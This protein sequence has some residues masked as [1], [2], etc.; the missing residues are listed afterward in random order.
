MIIIITGATHTGKTNLAQSLLNKNQFPYLSLDHLK[1]G[2]IRSHNSSLSTNDDD[3]LTEYLW[4]ITKE[5][6]KT[7][8]EN[9]QNLIIEGKYIPPTWQ[10]DFNDFY[11]NNI[12]FYCLV[13]SKNYIMNNIERINNYANIIEKRLFDSSC[14][15]EELIKENEDY[16]NMCINNN[17]NYVLIDKDY[18]IEI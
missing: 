17:L 15:S 1:M 3:K 16:L 14:Q 10:N 8:I 9:N 4:P 7:T 18:K 5:I 6:I 13:M 2:L 12:K 11:L